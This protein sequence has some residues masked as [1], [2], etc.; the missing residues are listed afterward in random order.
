MANDLI[1]FN[2]AVLSDDGNQAVVEG[3]EGGSLADV[4]SI[5]TAKTSVQMSTAMTNDIIDGFIAGTS[6]LQT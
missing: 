1:D 5:N 4:A 2:G 6:T 3:K